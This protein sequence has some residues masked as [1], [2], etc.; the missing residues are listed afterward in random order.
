MFDKNSLISHCVCSINSSIPAKISSRLHSH[1]SDSCM[2]SSQLLTV[3]A[4][5]VRRACH[6]AWMCGIVQPICGIKTASLFVRKD[7]NSLRQRETRKKRVNLHFNIRPLSSFLP[8]HQG[9]QGPSDD[10]LWLC[11]WPLLCLSAV[12]T[13]I[14]WCCWLN[15][16]YSASECVCVCVCLRG[17]CCEL[18]GPKCWFKGPWPLIC[19]LKVPSPIFFLSFSMWMSSHYLSVRVWVCVLFALFVGEKVKRDEEK[20]ASQSET[21]WMSSQRLCRAPSFINW[22]NVCGH[23]IILLWFQ[24]FCHMFVFE[25]C[26][27]FLQQNRQQTDMM[28]QI[29]LA[30]FGHVVQ[31][32]V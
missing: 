4:A 19:W 9:V 12:S 25:K 26:V 14:N 27:S 13:T 24:S 7:S 15:R 30:T 10:W 20:A 17:N 5:K 31:L 22:S 23:L 2:Q 16:V 3:S 28:S 29:S 8:L 6:M 11:P 32:E 1:A 18:K 21:W